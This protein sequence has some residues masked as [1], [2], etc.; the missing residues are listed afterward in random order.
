MGDVDVWSAGF[1]LST[2]RGWIVSGAG[3][4]EQEACERQI[5]GEIRDSEIIGQSGC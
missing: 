4:R 3:W 1:T 5:S 2:C